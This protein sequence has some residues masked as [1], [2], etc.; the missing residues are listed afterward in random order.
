M[1]TWHLYGTDDDVVDLTLA[2]TWQFLRWLTLNCFSVISFSVIAFGALLFRHSLLVKKILSRDPGAFKHDS[3]SVSIFELYKA[4]QASGST[5]LVSTVELA[6]DSFL[7]EDGDSNKPPTGPTLPPPLH[8]LHQCF[9][10]LRREDNIESKDDRL[11][12]D[13][14]LRYCSRQLFHYSRATGTH[15]F[16]TVMNAV[17]SSVKMQHFQKAVDILVL[18]PRLQSLAAVIGWDL[19]TNDTTARRLMMESLWACKS[20]DSLSDIKDKDQLC[21]VD[22][23][24]DQ[25][26]YRL[27]LAYFSAHINSGLEWTM[28]SFLYPYQGQGKSS[29]NLVETKPADAFVANLVLE[30]LAMHSPIR[31]LFDVVPDVKLKHARALLKMCPVASGVTDSMRLQDVEIV[32][33]HFGVQ[34]AVLTLRAMEKG[35]Q[36]GEKK[37]L[38]LL[39]L[40]LLE[41]LK[42]HILSISNKPRRIF[43]MGLVV[44]LL[45]MDDASTPSLPGGLEL[46]LDSMLESRNEIAE[47]DDAT[48]ITTIDLIGRLLE[49]LRECMFNSLSELDDPVECAFPKGFT[50]PSCQKA[51]EWKNANIARF[52]EDWNWRLAVLQRLAPSVHRQWQWNEALAVLRAAPSTLLNLCVQRAQYDLGKEAVSRFALPPEDKA[53]LQLAEWVD[54]AVARASVDDAVSQVAEGASSPE[55][56]LKLAALRAPLA[57][58]ANVLLCIDVA[59][60]SARAV[61]MS[62]QLLQKARSLLSDI[63]SGSIHRQGSI[64]AEQIQESCILSV[65]KRVVQ[66]LQELL[67][68]VCTEKGQTLQALLSGMDMVNVVLESVKHGHRYRALNILQQTIEDAHNGKRQFLSGKLHNLVKA[69]ADDESEE[70]LIKASAPFTD[71]KS[72]TVCDIGFLLGYGLRGINKQPTTS[73][74]GAVG[75]DHVGETTFF[76]LK[77]TGKRY[78]GPLVSKPLAYLSAFILYIATIGDIVDGVDTTH[79]F[80]F[81]TLVYERSNDLLT[82]LVFERRSANAAGKVAEIMGADLAQEVISACVPP[83]YPPKSSRGW[84]CVPLL[85]FRE[86]NS[87]IQHDKASNSLVEQESGLYPLNLDVVKHLNTLSPVRAILA[88]VFGTSRFQKTS[89]NLDGTIGAPSGNGSLSAETDRS[90]YEFALDKSDRFSTLNRWIQTQAN[91]QQLSEIPLSTKKGATDGQQDVEGNRAL[92]KRPREHESDT[93]SEEDDEKHGGTDSNYSL[94]IGLEK[95]WKGGGMYDSHG[96]TRSNS[97]TES[98]EMKNSTALMFEWENESIYEDTVNRL[99]EEGKM[100]DALALAD[101]YLRGGAPDYLLRL[102]IENTDGGAARTGHWQSNN[103]TWQYCIR[104]RDKKLATSLAVK[105]FRSWDL[106]SAIDVLTMCSCHLNDT[107]SL[108]DEVLQLKQSLQLYSQ[109]L[110]ADGRFTNWQEIESICQRDPEELALRLAGRG[111]VS[112]ALEVAERYSLREDLRRELQGRQLVKILTSD[113]VNGGGPAEALRFLGSLNV[114]EDALP[115][116]MAAMEQLPSLQ[117]KQLLV[118]FFLKKQ[119]GILSPDELLGLQKLALGL[120]MLGALPLPWQQRCAA[121]HQHPQLILETLLMWKQL[122]VA[123]EACF[124]TLKPYSL[125]LFIVDVCLSDSQG[126]DGLSFCKQVGPDTIGQHASSDYDA[127]SSIMKKNRAKGNGNGLPDK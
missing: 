30:R 102:L 27:D 53:A 59:A 19:L 37:Q 87:D 113:P 76:P 11:N 20:V 109:I 5:Y 119:V 66:C 8:Y 84:A 108:R 124:T 3:T 36:D 65:G 28:N 2:A 81:F 82:R 99:L 61:D 92:L 75:G 118:H 24:C 123:S 40:S 104:L 4:I 6:Q 38:R 103:M 126:I 50:N 101:R 78:L 18:F 94:H 96:L 9:R 35:M 22:H 43:L 121:L 51:W 7:H 127:S 112:A 70:N 60:A 79:D 116:A 93:E 14:L 100:V 64:Q 117:A 25:L 74:V 17:L 72:N 73:V 13:G 122:Q 86:T 85:P 21:C 45:L 57:P 41:D 58:M 88:C 12:A 90:F 34:T 48:K 77:G 110:R 56:A 95:T 31:V 111:A 32:E 68:K 125:L 52:I 42:A 46:K 97:K 80:N 71:K 62:K 29:K 120:Q 105:H 15:M 63:P 69:L 114:P 16:D 54:G 26:C 10:H 47:S 44:D 55:E 98:L 91:L 23:L 39:A 83:I 106:E 115:V 67:E 33:L 107:D 1:M 89:R 49:T